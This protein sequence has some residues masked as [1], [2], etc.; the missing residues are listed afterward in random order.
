[1]DTPVGVT[2]TFEVQEIVKQGTVWGPKLCCGQTDDI[3]R[4]GRLETMMS[5]VPIN[6]RVFV[7]DM[8]ALGNYKIC[9]SMIN[10]S[11]KFFEQQKKY[12]FSVE[13]TNVLRINND[14]HVVMVM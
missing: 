7:D 10:S 2:D 6:C 14:P 13:K 3:N 4:Y 9:S 11:C 1:M 8:A 5:T 12:T